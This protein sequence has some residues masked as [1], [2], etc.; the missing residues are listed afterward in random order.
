MSPAASSRRAAVAAPYARPRT[1]QASRTGSAD[2]RSSRNSKWKED[3]DAKS[4]ANSWSGTD[5]SVIGW[6]SEDGEPIT[7]LMEDIFDVLDRL[8][9]GDR[10]KRRRDD[11]NNAN[12]ISV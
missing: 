11:N 7:E 9:L 10:G 6:D 5:R 12:A 1:R 4:E 2:S 3:A 8:A